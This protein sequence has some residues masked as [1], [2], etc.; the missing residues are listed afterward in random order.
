VFCN[1]KEVCSSRG[2][3]SGA[4]PCLLDPNLPWGWNTI[5][6]TDNGIYCDG[7][8]YC[9]AEHA[10]T[11]RDP[12]PT[13][14]S[15]PCVK[16]CLAGV[17]HCDLVPGFCFIDF[18]CYPNGAPNPDDPSEHEICDSNSDP[19]HWSSTKHRP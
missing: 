5:P 18:V 9:T 17:D 7:I 15:A 11:Q 8:P 3:Q 4:E 1:G 10:C 14:G 2:C 13:G 6:C 12:C 16:G 19:F